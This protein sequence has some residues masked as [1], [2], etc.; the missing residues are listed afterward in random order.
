[1]GT[2]TQKKQSSIDVEVCDIPTGTESMLIHLHGNVLALDI[3][4]MYVFL[5]YQDLQKTS[6]VC[7]EGTKFAERIVELIA[8]VAWW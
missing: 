3:N 7:A 5:D 4:A 2:L 6:C 8:N 1:M